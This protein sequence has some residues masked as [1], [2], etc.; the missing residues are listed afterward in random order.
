M[1]CRW[2]AK[3]DKHLAELEERLKAREI[4]VPSYEATRSKILWSKGVCQAQGH[5]IVSN[6]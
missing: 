5:T 4:D 1:A 6:N 3:C 2:C